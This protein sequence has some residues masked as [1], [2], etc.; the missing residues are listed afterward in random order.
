MTFTG[1]STLEVTDTKQ[2]VGSSKGTRPQIKLLNEKNEEVKLINSDS[3]V[4][5]YLPKRLYYY[6]K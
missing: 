4:N 5:V 3:P 1:L 2:K 6:C